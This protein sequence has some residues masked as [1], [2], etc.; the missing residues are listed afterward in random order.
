MRSMSK[1]DTPIFCATLAAGAIVLSL[2]APGPASAQRQSR[3]AAWQ[4]CTSIAQ[5]QYPDPES[6]SG[7]TAVFKSCMAQTGHRP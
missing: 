5:Q 1:R 2:A 4:R 3:D 6:T 7:R